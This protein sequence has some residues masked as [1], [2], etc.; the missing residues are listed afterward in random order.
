MPIFFD[1]R[2]VNLSL[3]IVDSPTDGHADGLMDLC[4]GIIAVTTHAKFVKSWIFALLFN[5]APVALH[6]DFLTRYNPGANPAISRRRGDVASQ[7]IQCVAGV[8]RAAPDAVMQ[9]CARTEQ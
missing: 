6:E 2:I 9:C 7:V 8:P 4:L 3:D 1:H 5:T